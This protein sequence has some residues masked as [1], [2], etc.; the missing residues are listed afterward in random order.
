MG[1]NSVCCAS[2]NPLD[3]RYAFM[4][5]VA[6]SVAACNAAALP[7]GAAFTPAF[8]VIAAVFN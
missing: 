4:G 2:V 7:D 8:A 1:S 5:A 3:A 6:A